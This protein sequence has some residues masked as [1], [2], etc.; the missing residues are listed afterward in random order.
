MSRTILFIFIYIIEAFILWSYAIQRFNSKHSKKYESIF[1][2]IGYTTLFLVSFTDSFGI[3]TFAFTLM[4]FIIFKALYDTTWISAFFHSFITT[5]MMSFSEI[6][7]IG[8]FN[9]FNTNVLYIQSD[10][11]SLIILTA[12]SKTLYFIS[13]SIIARVLPGSKAEQDHTNKSAILINIIPFISIYITVV[14][15]SVLLNTSVSAHFRHMI[16]L[17]AILLILINVLVFYIYNYTQQKNKEF[18][19][20]QVQFQKEYDMSEYY[21]TLFNKNEDQQILIHDIRNHLLS[22]SRLNEHND[23]EEISRYLNT[24]LNSSELQK[25]AQVSDNEL[26]N[27]ILCH[28]IQIC[29]TEHI[30]FNIDVRKKVLTELNYSDLTSLFGNLLDNAVEASSNIPNSYI[31]LSITNKEN[32]DITII[33]LVNKCRTKPNFN[34]NGKPVSTKKNK[35]QHGFGIKSIERIVKKYNGDITMYFDNEKSTFHTIIALKDRT[36]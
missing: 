17:C 35:F 15:T 26:L 16:S 3:N 22:I 6:V 5:C 24:L 18:T 33:N 14:L 11:M 19:L 25:S 28:Y 32:T 20:L 13:I 29:Q 30:A 31:E 1:I 9:Q 27:S 10:M 8:L 7:I 36:S 21:K 12:L 4:N 23:R 34:K 2:L